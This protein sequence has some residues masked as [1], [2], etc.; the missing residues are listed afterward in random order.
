MSENT[1]SFDH[2]TV[3]SGLIK[4]V[5][6]QIEALEER[7]AEIA[8]DIKDSHNAYV[9]ANHESPPLKAWLTLPNTMIGNQVK[10]PSISPKISHLLPNL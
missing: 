7:K 8:T 6:A 5:V 4:Q 2:V 9:A 1:T 3:A 10:N